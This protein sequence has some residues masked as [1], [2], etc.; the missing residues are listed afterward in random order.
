MDPKMKKEAAT[1]YCPRCDKAF[2]AIGL[3]AFANLEN[4]LQD[5]HPDYYE[6]FWKD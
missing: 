3:Q 5:A 6:I 1:V 4:H 2:T